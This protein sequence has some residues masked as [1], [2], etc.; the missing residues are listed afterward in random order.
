MITL[1]EK[2]LDN[3]LRVVVASNH[4]APVVTLGVAYKVGSKDEP[5][6]HTGLA[7]LFEHLMFDN[8]VS[9]RGLRFDMYVT[10]AGGES[11][12]YTNYDHTYYHITLPSNA[13]ETALWLE[14]NRME[15]FNISDEALRTQIDVV[16]EEI[17]QVVYN[18]P[19]GTWDLL[20]N[21]TAFAEAS[22]YSWEIIGSHE[23]VRATTM[24]DARAWYASRYRPDN[25]V[26]VLSGDI[27]AEQGF[28]LAE[29]YF[30]HITRSTPKAT[31]AVFRAA[32]KRTGM[33]REEQ[34]VPF[35]AVFL[36]YHMDGFMND[37]TL[38]ADVLASILS[39]G[40]SSRL[41]K[42]FQHDRQIASDVAAHADRRECASL[43]TLYAISSRDDVH[44]D[45]LEEVFLDGIRSLLAGGVSDAE[46]DKAK[47]VL[48]TR[49]AHHLQTSS[50]VADSVAQ[51]ALFWSDA[52]RV[53]T[54]LDKL[55][56]IS[57]REVNDFA[58]AVFEAGNVKVE[59]VAR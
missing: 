20:Q 54:V 3:G 32:D 35:D 48:Q 44:A 5:S 27:S 34:D 37:G 12:A 25:A 14:S 38:A 41:Y 33:V 23:H 8:I 15:G 10:G 56:S 19:Y 57:T 22:M 31:A 52:Y 50:G 9:E 4:K 55:A 46:V 40:R 26:V 21:R 2:V 28:A 11:N 6:S 43:F 18:R 29:K 1:S 58:R 36:G 51:S 24:D 42:A 7:H 17:L 13:V 16:S 59:I 45:Q 47:N 30:A 49:L 53:N 39:D